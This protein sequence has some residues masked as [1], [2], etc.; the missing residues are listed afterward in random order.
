M[1]HANRRAALMLLA[2]SLSSGTHAGELLW[3]QRPT[4]LS[5][6]AS[7]ASGNGAIATPGNAANA[8]MRV[9]G[10]GASMPLADAI[11][12]VVPQEYKV[13]WAQGAHR[14][15][16]QVVSWEGKGRFWTEVLSDIV[17]AVRLEFSIVDSRVVISVVGGGA[18]VEMPP[19]L[20]HFEARAGETVKAT[21]SRWSGA[22]G[23]RLDWQA[24]HD[25]VIEFGATFG[26]DFEA[27]VDQLFE[28]FAGTN[29]KFDPW[30]SDNQV[31]IVRTESKL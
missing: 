22:A 31:L 15:S 7:A 25:A 3:K 13:E 11:T 27:S 14:G 29:P 4:N 28:G 20:P 2:L 5:E 21:L 6:T 10:F 1:G 12:A 30:K 19:A 17:A 16:D 9:N 23:W 18:E 26:D 24:S 8:T